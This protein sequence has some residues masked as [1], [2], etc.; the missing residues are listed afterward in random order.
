M[1][2]QEIYRRALFQKSIDDIVDLLGR[3][4]VDLMKLKRAY[5][6]R[7]KL[8]T[9]EQEKYRRVAQCLWTRGAIWRV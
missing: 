4:Q 7:A 8:R 3:E 2:L 6:P 5:K 1:T 9:N